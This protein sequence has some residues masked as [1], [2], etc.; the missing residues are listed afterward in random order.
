MK[1]K[2]RIKNLSFNFFFI[3]LSGIFVTLFA[4]YTTIGLIFY[5]PKFFLHM[6]VGNKTFFD[7]DL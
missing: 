2:K 3:F 7:L 1:I 6:I 5:E 4:F